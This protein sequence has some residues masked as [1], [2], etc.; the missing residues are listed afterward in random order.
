MFCCVQLGW[1]SVS[2]VAHGIFQNQRLFVLT[3]LI[4]LWGYHEDPNSCSLCV[5]RLLL[6]IVLYIRNCQHNCQ[7]NCVRACYVICYVTVYVP[8]YVTVICVLGSVTNEG[9]SPWSGRGR[10]KSLVPT[11]ILH[12][13]FW[14]SF[15]VK[16]IKCGGE[17]TVW[18]YSSGGVFI[19]SK[20]TII[21]SIIMSVLNKNPHV[22]KEHVI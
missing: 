13:T 8:D 10:P 2:G 12:I 5:A 1:N 14:L 17:I 15:V 18:N 11:P 19:K 7:C 20:K 22:Y 4:N 16:Y 9:S 3:S 21:L 6:T